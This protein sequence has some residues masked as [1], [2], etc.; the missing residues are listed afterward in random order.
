M[1]RDEAK[2]TVRYSSGQYCLRLFEHLKVRVVVEQSHAHG[3]SIGL[4]LLSH[5]P[6][7]PE[8]LEGHTSRKEVV[9]VSDKPNKRMH[10]M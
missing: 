10:V 2:I 9:R 6:I 7:R 8:S 3:Y 5:Q 1:Q 4:L